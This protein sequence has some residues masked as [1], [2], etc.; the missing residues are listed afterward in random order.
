[1]QSD[2]PESP[3]TP[4]V[5]SV[6]PDGSKQE[7][8]RKGSR[9]MPLDLFEQVSP[10]PDRPERRGDS[11]GFPIWLGSALST[12]VV[13]AL[14]FWFLRGYHREKVEQPLQVLQNAQPRV[15]DELSRIISDTSSLATTNAAE[16]VALRSRLNAVGQ[17]INALRE[18]LRTLPAPAPPAASAMPD[19]D[20]DAKLRTA[21]EPLSQR[22][23]ALDALMRETSAKLAAA[24]T[25]VKADPSARRGSEEITDELILLKERNRLTLLA[26][27]VMATGKSEAMRR[28]WVAVR[29]PAVDLLQHAAAAEIIRVQ[30]HLDGITRLP[31]GYRIAVKKHFPDSTAA[32]DSGLTT[33]QLAT[34]LT[35]S[36]NPLPTRARAA[37]LLSG[38]RSAQAGDALMEALRN[39]PDLDVVKECQHAM[40]KSFGMTVPLFDLQAAE[41]WWVANRESALKSAESPTKTPPAIAPARDG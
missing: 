18:Q 31:P 21:L 1:M 25:V 35:N 3:P 41:A 13:L 4:R 39:D 33:D 38:Q 36:E 12:A 29:E 22:L 7:N 34:L 16:L 30:N 37:V 24:S 6:G 27:E 5:A 9:D 20:V 40:R 14:T 15:S 8:E 11:P 17:E 32:E 2:K 10:L 28:L 19:V 26:D 23:E